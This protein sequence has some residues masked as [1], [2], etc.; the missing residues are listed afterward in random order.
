[1]NNRFR[2][3]SV[4][5]HAL[6]VVVFFFGWTQNQLHAQQ[7]TL[8]QDNIVIVKD[9]EPTIIQSN[10]ISLMPMNR[11]SVMITPDINYIL[12]NKRYETTFESD[13]IAAAKMKSEPLSKIY[14]TYVKAGLG[15]YLNHMIDYN[16][17]NLRSRSWDYG[18]IVRHFGSD[19]GIQEF[20]DNSFNRQQALLYGKKYLKKHTLSASGNFN[21]YKYQYYGFQPDSNLIED[22]IDFAQ[23]YIITGGN[24]V[25]K[26]FHKDSAD[27][28]YT[29]SG[30]YN[31]LTTLTGELEH[32]ARVDAEFTRFF[33][34]HKFL[35]YASEDFNLANQITDTTYSN[36]VQLSPQIIL[37]KNKVYAKVGLRAIMNTYGATEYFYF[38]PEVLFRYNIIKEYLVPY[39][40]ITGNATRLGLNGLF[41]ENQFASA[42]SQLRN[43][44]DLTF[45]GG[46][47]GNLGAKFAYNIMASQSKVNDMAFFINDTTLSLQ[48]QFF[49]IYD[50]VNV[51][52]LTGELSY[53]FDS[54][55][56]VIARASYKNYVA[57]NLLSAWQK[58]WLTAMITGSYT[59]KDKYVFKTDV[60]FY[61]TRTALTN[62]AANNEYLGYGEYAITLP[63]FAD[64]NVG[65][66]Y[67][68]NT[69]VSAFVQLNNILAN[70]YSV[71]NQYQVQRFNVLGGF[72]YKFAGK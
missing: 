64:W 31:Y 47:R 16:Y 35:L 29:I 21:H 34:G 41:N 59:L 56:H 33:N 68:Y 43:P 38:R 9:Y 61:S 58:P 30:K 22:S 36:I 15:N 14:R 69:K 12:L 50:T 62:V 8:K 27:L 51:F 49:T 3:S 5:S 44:V 40:G 39:A 26:S 53:H 32:N 66:E 4:F 52:D 67:K 17:N 25:L 60:N 37:Q 63:A 19:G 46:F 10:K 7:D 23:R 48:N 13:P 70:K 55:L 57:N 45:F 24:V 42:Q 18:L 72:T 6:V 54:K 11:D 2:I 65:F 1:M 71:W 20:A 28:N